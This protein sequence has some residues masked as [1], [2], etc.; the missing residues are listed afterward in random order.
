MIWQH[1]SPA[2][3]ASKPTSAER[4]AKAIVWR[5]AILIYLI[6]F[7][8]FSLILFATPGF[9]GTDDYYHV[10]IS[11]QIIEQGRLALNFPWLPMTLLSPERFVD[12][13]LLFHIYLS[14]WVVAYGIVGAKL[15]TISIAA[16]L[17]LALWALMRQI[18]VQRAALWTA[19]LFGL[20]SPFLT[21]LL[22]IRTQ[23]AA[24]LFL[25]LALSAMFARRYWLLV[26]LAFGF[27]WLYNGFVLLFAVTAVYSA[28]KWSADRQFD[29]RPVAYCLLGLAL[30]LVINPY[31][32]A[33]LQF[34]GEHLGAKLDFES[35][36]TVG[37][38]WYPYSTGVLMGN[39][40]GALIALLLGFLYPTFAGRPQRDRIE[41]T[42]LFVALVTLF[43][44]F[45]SRRFI[46]YFPPF[47]LL[48]CA[49]VWGRGAISPALIL[50][51]YLPAKLPG[52]WLSA[53]G[54]LI[55]VVP[56]AL[57]IGLTCRDTYREAQKSPPVERYAGASAWLRENTPPQSM[58]FQTDWDDFTRLFY[59]NT[60]NVY[61]VGLDPTYLQLAQPDL[62]SL[63]VDITQGDIEQPSGYI[64]SDFGAHYV[65]SDRNHKGF[66]RAARA[67]PAMTLV[68]QDSESYIWYIKGLQQPGSH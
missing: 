8:V 62:W 6:S 44:L 10:R 49:A 59:H 20:S 66:E 7:G 54:W 56:G 64:V 58:V 9:L 3:A 4:P 2:I 37:N 46:E 65:F 61:L 39:S 32:P 35:S 68:Y 42:L 5:Q 30:G 43:M 14:P 26:L 22:M 27:V 53:L 48:F 45:R 24:A 60:H 31:F 16:A 23:G 1:V 51:Q 19:L 15:G 12:H 63:W 33:N 21:R 17:C 52:R 67:D 38:E 18:G 34:I 25:I 36:V 11:A 41:N 47:A 29:L 40:A 57:M 28:A 50:R 55:V 13:H